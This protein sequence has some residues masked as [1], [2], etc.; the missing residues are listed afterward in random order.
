MPALKVFVISLK[1]QSNRRSILMAKL[2]PVI[3]FEFI[4]ALLGSEVLAAEVAAGVKRQMYSG[5]IGRKLTAN[6]I[7]CSLSHR[8]ALE[9]FLQTNAQWGLILEDDAE[10]SVIQRDMIFEMVDLLADRTDCDLI[11]VGGF[12]DKTSPGEVIAATSS[13]SVLNVVTFGVCAHGYIVSRRGAEKIIRVIEPVTEPYD[14]FLRSVY[15]HK[16]KMFET[17]PWL[18]SLQDNHFVSSTITAQIG[19]LPKDEVGLFTKLKGHFDKRVYN[20]QKWR[21]GILHF[22]VKYIFKK[23]MLS[24][25]STTD[26]RRL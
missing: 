9:A 2:F 26:H 1:N 8:K 3:E 16:C 12:G 4:D 10:I 17:A 20:L 6:E 18:V 23:R 5:R 15:R 19:S 25:F 24:Q 13:F 11:K 21:H 14:T 7:G 22:G